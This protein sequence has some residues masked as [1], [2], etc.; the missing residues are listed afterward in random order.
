MTEFFS[1]S[2]LCDSNYLVNE[3]VDSNHTTTKK[4]ANK[5]KKR[6]NYNHDNHNNHN[7][8]KNKKRRY[9]NTPK[10]YENEKKTY[11]KTP[12]VFFTL[13]EPLILK[14]KTSNVKIFTI[15][16]NESYFDKKN[17]D[18][19]K[20]IT[21]DT[22]FDQFD[23]FHSITSP[24]SSPQFISTYKNKNKNSPDSSTHT[25]SKPLYEKSVASS[26]DIF[27]SPYHASYEI[28]NKIEINENEI[29][30]TDLINNENKMTEISL[31]DIIP[32]TLEYKPPEMTELRP[33]LCFIHCN[34]PLFIE[35]KDLLL[36]KGI[37]FSTFLD[38]LENDEKFKYKG[39][40]EFKFKNKY[41]SCHNE[42]IKSKTWYD[43]NQVCIKYVGTNVDYALVLNLYYTHH[44]PTDDERVMLNI[45]LNIDEWIT[46]DLLAQKKKPP[47]RKIC[48]WFLLY[49]LRELSDN[50]LKIYVPLVQ[51]SM[52]NFKSK[53]NMIQRF[54]RGIDDFR[55]I[56]KKH[57]APSFYEWKI[58][59]SLLN[60]QAIESNKKIQKM[61]MSNVKRDLFL[62][63]TKSHSGKK[64]S[65]IHDFLDDESDV[66]YDDEFQYDPY[67]GERH[68]CLE[69][70]SMFAVN[71]FHELLKNTP[72]QFEDISISDCYKQGHKL[73][74]SFDTCMM[75]CTRCGYEEF[76]LPHNKPNFIMEPSHLNERSGD[77]KKRFLFGILHRM[78]EDFYSMFAHN[79]WTD[80]C[81]A[82][83]K[84]TLDN[85]PPNKKTMNQCITSLRT[86][87]M[88]RASMD[89]IYCLFLLFGLSHFFLK[90]KWPFDEYYFFSVC[91]NFVCYSCLKDCNMADY[92][93]YKLCQ[94]Y[95][96][97][98]GTHYASFVP[99]VMCD[100][101][102]GQYN[103]SWR[104]YCQNHADSEYNLVFI[105]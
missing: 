97:T 90:I 82:L 57:I 95:D 53:F 9:N 72:L 81:G 44:H 35:Y 51:K 77:I 10:K 99:F 105:K 26:S 34:H 46:N 79:I 70:D 102:Y 55:I 25:N 101:T 12:N 84:Y 4:F 49:M 91:N 74:K 65:T 36:K 54:L 86:F 37:E 71:G 31:D 62:G 23:K 88:A 78:E 59:D 19:E 94:I 32:L 16:E 87:L 3:T 103:Q 21:I 92:V 60:K 83:L 40:L 13:E 85:P 43:F 29:L 5:N 15:P 30:Q 8:H 41:S 58:N 64:N 66:Q 48:P 33:D 98:N 52:N 17:E 6:K 75:V 61:Q 47:T 67:H 96:N 7:N 38:I 24:P 104:L 14:G 63:Y 50:P 56:F 42:I 18:E 39:E 2:N 89:K 22:P 80:H 76:F 100:K 11:N 73:I 27:N 69:Y 28:E 20:Q 93:L 45:L 68:D 1:L